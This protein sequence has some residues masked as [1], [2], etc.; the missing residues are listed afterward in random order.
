MRSLFVAGLAAVLGLS[1]GA[2]S[3]RADEMELTGVHLCC[4]QCVRVAS[5]VVGK[6]EG[7]TDTKGDRNGKKLTFTAKDQKTGQAAQKAL[8]DAGFFGILMIGGKEVPAEAA[9]TAKSDKAAELTVSKVHLCCGACKNAAKAL[10]KDSTVDFPGTNTMK[11]TG[12]DLDKS[13]VLEVL[14]KAGFGGK[15]D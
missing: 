4:N 11:L 9:A 12:K 7:V 3:A 2:V 6:V 14:N 1:A 10:F 5:Q 13:K 8:A 15:I